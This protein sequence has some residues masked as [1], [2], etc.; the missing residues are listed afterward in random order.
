MRQVITSSALVATLVMVWPVPVRGGEPSAA[1]ILTS[2]PVLLASL[3]RIARGSELFRTAV[4]AARPTGR[5]VIVLTPDAVVVV[6]PDTDG[7]LQAFDSTVLA[8]VALVPGDGR[9]IAAVLVVIN[10]PLFEEVS[11]RRGLSPAERDADL[12]RILIHEVYGHALPY[13]IAGDRSGRCPDPASGERAAD[14][15]SIQRENAVRAELGLGRRTDYGLE[16]LALAQ[17]APRRY[18]GARVP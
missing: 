6:D 7:F 4:E 2:H 17:A 14:A 12:D 8:D 9:A 18:A 5:R 16:S 3:E 15:C 10:L 1:P 11:A 13:A